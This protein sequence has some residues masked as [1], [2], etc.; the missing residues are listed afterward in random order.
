MI[1][2]RS[3]L[4][5]TVADLEKGAEPGCTAAKLGLTGLVDSAPATSAP[6]AAAAAP[7]AAPATDGVSLV[8]KVS[9]I[10]SCL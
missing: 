8:K 9:D 5:S 3:K 1:E 7:A 2:G 4:F 6:G 10:G